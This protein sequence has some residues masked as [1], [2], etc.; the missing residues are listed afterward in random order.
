[1]LFCVDLLNRYIHD[2]SQVVS[3]HDGLPRTRR[4]FTRS[5]TAYPPN[6]KRGIIYA[7]EDTLLFLTPW[8]DVPL[9]HALCY[10]FPNDMSRKSS[11]D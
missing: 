9:Q 7:L 11:N 8:V 2:I 10:Y 5:C 1:M 4:T 3:I 6:H